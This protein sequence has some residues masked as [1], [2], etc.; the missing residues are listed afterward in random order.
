MIFRYFSS[1]PNVD[2]NKSDYAY[3]GFL[4]F[5]PTYRFALAANVT[6]ITMICNCFFHRIPLVYTQVTMFIMF[7][8]FFFIAEELAKLELFQNE[9][10]YLKLFYNEGIY[11]KLFQNE[12]MYW[13]LLQ[14]EGMY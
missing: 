8:L 6:R 9:R 13:K 2:P 3:D 7:F 12:G 11:W 1:A 4:V 14:N 10:M 5:L